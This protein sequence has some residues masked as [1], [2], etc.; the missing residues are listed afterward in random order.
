[1]QEEDV[2]AIVYGLQFP[3]V[4]RPLGEER[5]EFLGTCY[6]HGIMSGEALEGRTGE[7][8]VLRLC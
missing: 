8:Y 2:V 4:L 3:V 7:D 5:F 1:M 6:V